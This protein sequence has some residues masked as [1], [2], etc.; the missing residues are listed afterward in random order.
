MLK[1]KKPAICILILICNIITFQSKYES[2]MNDFRNTALSK[3]DILN[4]HIDLI[5]G[6]ADFIYEF[7]SSHF[8]SGRTGQSKYLSMLKYNA[9]QNYYH[10]DAVQETELALKAG[11]ITGIG[12]IPESRFLLE[13]LNL[14]LQLNDIFYKLYNKFSDIKYL[15]YISSHNFI[16]RYPYILSEQFKFSEELKQQIFYTKASPEYNGRRQPVW[17]PVYINQTTKELII[18]YSIPIYNKDR[19]MGVVT[20][21]F[22]NSSFGEMMES[23][24]ESYL[25]DDLDT[26]IA[27]GKMNSLNNQAVQIDRLLNISEGS[28]S[29]M[30]HGNQYEIDR[31]GS[32]YVYA[33]GLGN[34]PWSLYFRVPVWSI[35]SQS[36]FTTLPIML[37]CLLLLLALSE[38]DKRKRTE[39]L[40]KDTI[41]ELKSYQILL[42]SAAKMDF[43]TT[44]YNRRGFKEKLNENITENQV[45]RTPIC[46]LIGDIDYFKQY[47]DTYGHAAGD[48]VLIKAAEIMKKNVDIGDIVCRWGGEEFLIML[49][50]KT[51]E[52]ALEVAEK[53]R[54]KIGA[55]VIRLEHSIEINLTITIGVAEFKEEESFDE[56]VSK[57]DRALYIGK[58][59]GR[60]RVAGSRD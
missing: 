29:D 27:S 56:C 50:N 17:S 4:R 54:Q 52:E 10:L 28:L 37:I 59:M 7:G 18:T 40:L 30:K 5:S 25:V 32:Y 22:S 60:N 45:N 16:N 58:E 11:N 51:Y 42:E 49:L 20:I 35:I 41:D 13:E 43:L 34:A 9:E 57:A 2:L 8:L 46:L 14:A 31:I 3:E 19:F 24:Y 33:L 39:K 38:L 47:N 53:I 44:T 21:D 12:P 55:T 1:L 48:K 15:S 26:V 36:L 23:R 6:Y